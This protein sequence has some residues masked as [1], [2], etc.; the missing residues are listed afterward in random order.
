MAEHANVASIDA[1]EAFRADL[2]QYMEKARVAL[3]DAEGE[4][5]RTRTWLDSDRTTYWTAQYKQR[6][7]QLEQ[8]EAELYN[9]TITS[10][11]ESHTF[12]KM[13]VM[14]ARR[15]LEEAEEKLR[16]LKKWRQTF[17]NRVTPLLRQLDPMFFMVGRH[18]PKGVHSLGES[19][20]AL[21]AYAEKGPAS[22]GLLTMATR[23]LQA[24]WTETRN[25][26]RDGKAD[27]FESLY[28]SELT[29]TMNTA[30]RALEDLDHLLEKIHADCD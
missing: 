26:W 16:V 20:K 3:E 30:L 4:V 7:K 6:V 23:K 17:D 10:P 15:K 11:S 13:A 9:V 27:E 14:K 24:S 22:R 2:I 5:R 12:Q 1:L 21:Q 18:L 25:K 19:I 29:N 28:L 8:A